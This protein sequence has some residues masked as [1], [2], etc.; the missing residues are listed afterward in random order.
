MNRAGAA[1]RNHVETP[2]RKAR[3]STSRQLP[4]TTAKKKSG[5]N[6]NWILL[7]I[8]NPMQP[9][10]T[11]MSVASLA[12][13]TTRVKRICL[14]PSEIWRTR[15]EPVVAFARRFRCATPLVSLSR[16]DFGMSFSCTHC[17]EHFQSKNR[18]FQHLRSSSCT[19]A[20][21][22]SGLQVTDVDERIA[23]VIGC[24]SSEEDWQASMGQSGLGNAE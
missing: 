17:H 22:T 23:L 4:N 16:H 8:L 5:P 21:V 12:V 14:G 15:T 20:A 11:A 3:S 10:R 9:L 24:T 13:S 18:L 7:R 2:S 19:G 1:T 6:E